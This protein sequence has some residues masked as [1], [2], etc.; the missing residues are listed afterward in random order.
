MSVAELAAA[1]GAARAGDNAALLASEILGIGGDPIVAAW[2]ES[3]HADAPLTAQLRSGR[4]LHWE[5]QRD[6]LAPDTLVLPVVLASGLSALDK[7]LTKAQALTCA[8]ALANLAQTFEE[9]DERAE[10]AE[11]IDGF[12]EGRRVVEEA[13]GEQTNWRRALLGLRAFRA[14]AVTEEG[15]PEWRI[16]PVLLDT[17]S[18]TRYVRTLDVADYIRKGRRLTISWPA[19][20]ARLAA[21]GWIRRE[22]QFWVPD[23]Q[24]R[25][26]QR[27][28][29]VRI[30]V[31][32]PELGRQDA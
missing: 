31:N 3:A 9:H 32:E 30:Y 28:E 6:L 5:R 17:D 26:R 20:N 14:L 7:P 29:R 21:V 25:E 11:L 8:K 13:M 12:L 18:G 1:Q 22:F 19:L 15:I 4:R 2:R 10:M 27:R 23:G 16:A 24:P